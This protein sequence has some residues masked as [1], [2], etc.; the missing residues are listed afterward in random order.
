MRDSAFWIRGTNRRELHDVRN[1]GAFGRVSEIALELRQFGID[2]RDQQSFVDSF[3]GRGEQIRQGEIAIWHSK[4]L[5]V[6]FQYEKR[7]IS[8]YCW[9]SSPKPLRKTPVGGLPGCCVNG[10]HVQSL[11][12]NGLI[13]ITRKVS[14]RLRK[15][16]PVS[17]SGGA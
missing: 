2:G 12:L 16:L 17:V 5:C 10:I 7:S 3:Q 9:V 13:L 4:F 15:A 6:Q 8:S 11:V 14:S 1:T